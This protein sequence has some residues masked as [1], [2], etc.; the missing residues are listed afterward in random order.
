MVII[1]IIKI[2]ITSATIKSSVE[3]HKS[4]Y[5]VFLVLII[6]IM[7]EEKWEEKW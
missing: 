7:G 3:F 1:V 4:I 5:N 6:E 2:S